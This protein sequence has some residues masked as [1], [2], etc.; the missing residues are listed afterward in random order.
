MNAQEIRR[1]LG[2]ALLLV[3]PP[4]LGAQTPKVYVACYVPS[5]GTALAHVVPSTDQV[6][7]P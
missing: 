6:A 4:A 3:L 5:S 7:Y 1:T 2:V